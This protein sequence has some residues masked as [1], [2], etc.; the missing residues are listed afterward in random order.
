M[1]KPQN[2]SIGL[3]FADWTSSSYYNIASSPSCVATPMSTTQVLKEW[4]S[5]KETTQPAPTSTEELAGKTNA[6]KS[7]SG[8]WALV[9]DNTTSVFLDDE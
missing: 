9:I 3:I 8:L 1:N 5:A 7:T 6:T 2:K 4:S